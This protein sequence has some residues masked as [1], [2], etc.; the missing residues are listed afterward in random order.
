M[1]MIDS[2]VDETSNIKNHSNILLQISN[3][4]QFVKERY[5]QTAKITAE[6]YLLPSSSFNFGNSI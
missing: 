1:E 4:S 3:I 5:H 2:I 6:K